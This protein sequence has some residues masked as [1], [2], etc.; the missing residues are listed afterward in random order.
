MM[1]FVVILLVTL[2]GLGF[3]ED[4]FTPVLV[5]VF[6]ASSPVKAT[7]GKTHLIYALQLTNAGRVKATLNQ[8][9]VLASSNR[10]L[11]LKGS[12]LLFYLRHLNGSKCEN[13]EIEQDGS[14]LLFISMEFDD[15]KQAPKEVQ[16]QVDISGAAGPGSTSPSPLTYIAGRVTIPQSDPITIS[17]PLKGDGWVVF[18]GCCSFL[19]AHQTSLLP[20]N[21]S[22]YNAQ[23][24]ALDTMQLNENGK[25]V[26]GDPNE[27]SNWFCYNKEVFAVS[28][29]TVV[30]VLDGVPDQIPGTLPDPNTITMETYTG[31]HVILKIK[32]DI[33][34]FY[35]HLKKGSI[36]VQVG[37]KI[38]MGSLIGHIGNS[39]NTSAP[40]LHLHLMSTLSPVASSPVPFVFEEFKLLDQ[41][42]TKRFYETESLEGI[43]SDPT[44]YK[45]QKH[46]NELPLDLNV[47]QY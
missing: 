20:I 18:N 19:G 7:D 41:V 15:L 43:F 11:N 37:D 24:F 2:Q 36:Q 35:A 34:T 26:E 44:S 17:P 5:S 14:R 31:N 10:L 22:L 21:G 3:A 33:Y 47:L 32:D 25:L 45:P 6:E 9:E 4:A 12:D 16:H 42:P 1:K 27:L 23:G 46:Q 29:G 30:S 28:D 8:V 38:S 39:G 13:S 40:H